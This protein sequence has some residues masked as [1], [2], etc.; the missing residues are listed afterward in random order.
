MCGRHFVDVVR[1]LLVVSDRKAGAESP[2]LFPGSTLRG[3]LLGVCGAL[4]TGLGAVSSKIVMDETA[5]L[6][7]TLIR[8]LASAL[9]TSTLIAASGRLKETVRQVAQPSQLRYFVPAVLCG[10][11]LG[12][13]CSQIGYKYSSVA[14]A[15]TLMHTTPLFVMPMVRI[16]YG[17]RITLIGVAGAIIAI[18]GVYLTASQ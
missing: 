4:C 15:I 18:G 6:E 3:V 11:W 13:W 1:I 9:C 7:A 5:A 2:G 10:T 8:I 16:A 12:L 14:V 17:T